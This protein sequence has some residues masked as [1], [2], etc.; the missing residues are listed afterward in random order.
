VDTEE[1]RARAA[2]QAT[3]ARYTFHGDRGRVDELAQCFTEDGVLEFIGEWTARGRD[4]IY[5]QTSSVT[6]ETRERT[7]PLLR[8]H[9]ATHH[10]EF[11]ADAE[12][13]ATTYFTAYTEIG[14]DH[15]GRYVDQLRRVDD[16]W[17]FAHRRIAV[18][19]W[20]P[21]TVYPGEA[22]RSADRRDS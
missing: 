15:V 1:V 5:T 18:D 4:E 21:D 2:I 12:A 11:A 3:V 19:W 17:L 10:V 9:L 7:H 20:A 8:H 13:R 6:G 22:A 14:P 16:D